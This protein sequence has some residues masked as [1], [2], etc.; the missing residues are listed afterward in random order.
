MTY[1]HDA[2]EEPTVP[3]ATIRWLVLAFCAAFWVAVG[4]SLLS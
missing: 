1:C 4:Y 3:A 2:M